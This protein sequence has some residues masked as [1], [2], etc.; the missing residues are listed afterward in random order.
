MLSGIKRRE[1]RE[2]RLMEILDVPKRVESAF[3]GR[4][5]KTNNTT[6][7]ADLKQ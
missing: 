1:W 3:I 2:W 4:R 6:P 5:L 7:I